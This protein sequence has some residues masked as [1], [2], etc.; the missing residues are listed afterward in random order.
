M[1]TGIGTFKQ[2]T[3]GTYTLNQ[4][5][6]STS[7][8]RQEYNGKGRCLAFGWNNSN[9]FATGSTAPRSS[10]VQVGTEPFIDGAYAIH[11][12]VNSAAVFLIDND[13]N[14][15]SYGNDAFGW[16]GRAGALTNQIA[17]KWRL[18]RPAGD[19]NCHAFKDDGTLWSW[20]RNVQGQ[21]GLNDNVNRSSPTQIPGQ[22]TSVDAE[23]IGID[24]RGGVYAMGRSP[25][26]SLWF[27]GN[28]YLG[29]NGLNDPDNFNRSSPTQIPGQWTKLVRTSNAV[30]AID[31]NRNLFGWG[32]AGSGQLGASQTIPRSSPIFIMGPV[33]NVYQTSD[34]SFGLA[35]HVDGTLWAWGNNGSGQLGQGDFMPRSSPVMIP[36][37]WDNIISKGST[38]LA[39]GQNTN[40]IWSWGATNNGMNGT[41]KSAEDKPQ[42]VYGEFDRRYGIIT[43]GRTAFAVKTDQP[44]ESGL[45]GWGLGDYGQLGL[46]ST[47][48]RQL[49]TRIFDTNQ[50]E[51]NIPLNQRMMPGNG[52]DIQRNT[53][54]FARS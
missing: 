3:E 36:G 7:L 44:G 5:Y 14:L 42:R 16:Q 22:W 51:L 6:K 25:V 1:S 34:G 31:Q 48:S 27:W 38:V 9:E 17:G 24:A 50:V 4:N 41:N 2:K 28:N 54:I 47:A 33:D 26:N 29:M 18:V 45:Y 23:P 43:N 52:G 15:F 12:N 53:F 39:F 46:N 49:P 19:Y 8:D 20:G 32:Q 10:P 37:A 21:L 30:Y 35:K 40:T 13:Q 11:Q